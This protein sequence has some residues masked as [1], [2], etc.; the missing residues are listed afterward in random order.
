[1]EKFGYKNKMAVP[2]IVKV[3]V[4]TSFGKEVATKGSGE[5]EK[6]PSYV[7]RAIKSLDTPQ[8]REVFGSDFSAHDFV[9]SDHS[10][11]NELVRTVRKVSPERVFVHHG[12]AEEFAQFL[13]LEGFD[14]SVIVDKQHAL[15]NFF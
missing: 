7:E 4:N 10:D 11:F 5:R 9:M 1:M 6:G 14:V 8:A 13:K 2:K 12:F 15:N 3:T